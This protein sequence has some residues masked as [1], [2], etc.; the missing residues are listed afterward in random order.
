M[1]NLYIVLIASVFSLLSS[2]AYSVTIYECEDEEGNITLQDRCPAGTTPA[3]EKKVRTG[4]SSPAPAAAIPGLQPDVDII[5]YA[6]K[7]CDACII[8]QSILKDYGAPFTEKDTGQ[9]DVKKEL[10]EKTGGTNTITVPTVLVGED[11]IAGFNKEALISKLESA[12]FKKPEP[13]AE[14][15]EAPAEAAPAELETEAPETESTR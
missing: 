13:E 12:G 1:K 4:T 8:T 7:G 14:T 11:V 6:T 5:L 10:N 15:E 9:E 2:Q 3:G